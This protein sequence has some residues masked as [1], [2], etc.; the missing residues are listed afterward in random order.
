MNAI[1]ELK[2]PSGLVAND[3]RMSAQ[4]VLQHAVTVQEVMRSVMRPD[5]HY[6]KIPG[7]DKP[8]LYQPGADVLCMTFRIAQRFAVEFAKQ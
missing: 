7:T 1:V 2:Q 6:G 4:Q 5:V 8:T 3:G